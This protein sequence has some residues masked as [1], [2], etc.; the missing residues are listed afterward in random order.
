MSKA[1]LAGHSV[2]VSEILTF[3]NKSQLL[4]DTKEVLMVIE[5]GFKS[6]RTGVL[7]SKGQESKNISI[8]TFRQFILCF[9]LINFYCVDCY[10]C[11]NSELLLAVATI[12]YV[13]PVESIIKVTAYCIERNTTVL[14]QRGNLFECSQYPTSTRN[15]WRSGVRVRALSA[16]FRVLG[17]RLIQFACLLPSARR[18]LRRKAKASHIRHGYQDESKTAV[19]RK[20]VS[21]RLYSECDRQIRYPRTTR[22]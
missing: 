1:I 15:I 20:A 19:E 9:L 13:N 7:Y 3:W 14:P 21:D 16:Y 11:F 12:V 22:R 18:R 10:K 5:M 17:N 4:G 2:I 6:F 8:Q